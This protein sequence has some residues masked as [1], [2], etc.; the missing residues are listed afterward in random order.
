MAHLRCCRFLLQ[1]NLDSNCKNANINCWISQFGLDYEEPDIL[2]NEFM[3]S[4]V[5]TTTPWHGASLSACLLFWQNQ[6]K[7]WLLLLQQLYLCKLQVVYCVT[8]LFGCWFFLCPLLVQCLSQQCLALARACRHS[9]VLANKTSHSNVEYWINS[10]LVANDDAF[11]G[12]SFLHLLDLE[13]LFCFSFVGLLKKSASGNA[14]K[15]RCSMCC[16]MMS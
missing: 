3:T 6:T 2:S 9:R 14:V 4:A 16:L 8:W 12:S 5:E 15:C 13:S 10:Y 11:L 7:Q 1:C